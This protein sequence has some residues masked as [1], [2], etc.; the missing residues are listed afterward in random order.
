[1]L[2][3]NK[4]VTLIALVVTVIVLL[5]LASIGTYSGL[6]AVRSSKY[7]EAISELKIMQ[8]KINELY[9]ENKSAE[10]TGANKKEYGVE[11]SSSGKTQEISKAYLSVETNN[12]TGENIGNIS[13]YRYFSKNYIKDT[14]DLEGIKYDFIANLKTRTVILLDGFTKDG[15]TYYALCQIEGEQYNINYENE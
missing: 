6:D 12:V 3:K 13:D 5:I 1:M 2:K 8:G 10:K 7:Y 14:L 9:E 15:Q 4:G 11:I